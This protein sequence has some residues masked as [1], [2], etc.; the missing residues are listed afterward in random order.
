[1]EPPDQNRFSREFNPWKPHHTG[2][3]SPRLL[4]MPACSTNVIKQKNNGAIAKDEKPTIRVDERANPAAKKDTPSFEFLIEMPVFGGRHPEYLTP[5]FFTHTNAAVAGH[6]V[7]ETG[8]R[9]I[10]YRCIHYGSERHGTPAPD[11]RGR[12]DVVL[13]VNDI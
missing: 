4:G 6:A 11:L 3:V 5:C 12:A 2:G 8:S 13:D 1:M 9:P 7:N 10:V